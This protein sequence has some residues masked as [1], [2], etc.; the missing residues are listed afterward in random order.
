A[1]VERLA[2]A[3]VGAA[4]A[5]VDTDADRSPR[6]L[7]AVAAK[8]AQKVDVDVRAAGQDAVEVAVGQVGTGEAHLLSV[9]PGLQRQLDLPRGAGVDAGAAGADHLQHL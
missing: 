3:A 1:A 9:E 8:L 6:R 2:A 5:R 7:A 4:A